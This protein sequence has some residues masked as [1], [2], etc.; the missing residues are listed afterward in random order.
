MTYFCTQISLDM[1]SIMHLLINT[2]VFRRSW[3]DWIN[4][5][6]KK[7]RSLKKWFKS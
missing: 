4:C 5:W 1:Q 7:S 3:R 6:K 2:S